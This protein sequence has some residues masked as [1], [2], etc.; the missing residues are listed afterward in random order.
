[1]PSKIPRNIR[2]KIFLKSFYLGQ[3]FYIFYETLLFYI[4]K[5]N[6]S[7]IEEKRIKILKII[8]FLF[9]IKDIIIKCM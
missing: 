7:R 9:R 4:I 5:K 3:I 1:M 2:I 8:I 6:F